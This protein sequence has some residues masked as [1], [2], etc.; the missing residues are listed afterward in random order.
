MKSLSKG[1]T[2]RKD[3]RKNVLKQELK[4]EQLEAVNGGVLQESVKGLK[5]RY[6]NSFHIGALAKS[7]R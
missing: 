7:R 5:D 1:F 2:R 4:R 6:M 3:P